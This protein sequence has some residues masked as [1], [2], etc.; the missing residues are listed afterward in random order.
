MR[1]I[2]L[3]E[4]LAKMFSEQLSSLAS[5]VVDSSSFRGIIMEKEI[6]KKKKDSKM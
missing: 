5:S 4:V 1:V 2:L 6:G 3:R